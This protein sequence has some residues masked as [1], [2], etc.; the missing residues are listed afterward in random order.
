MSFKDVN[1]FSLNLPI[2]ICCFCLFSCC[3]Q[4]HKHEWTPVHDAGQRLVRQA[5]VWRGRAALLRGHERHHPLPTAGTTPALPPSLL[6]S[7]PLCSALHASQLSFSPQTEM[8]HMPAPLLASYWIHPTQEICMNVLGFLWGRLY[9][10]G[11]ERGIKTPKFNIS[12]FTFSQYSVMVVV[13]SA[14]PGIDILFSTCSIF[15]CSAYMTDILS[16]P[17]ACTIKQEFKGSCH[18]LWCNPWFSFFFFFKHFLFIYLFYS[19]KSWECRLS[20]QPFTFEITD[21]NIKKCIFYIK[22]P[23]VE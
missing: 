20:T 21:H 5:E 6:H 13:P 12:V 4:N 22:S 8:S 17:G 2:H 19:K 18:N 10:G 1:G 16:W 14:A 3:L 23:I 7:A 15:S 9:G 11:W